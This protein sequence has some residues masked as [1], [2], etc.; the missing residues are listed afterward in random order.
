MTQVIVIVNALL[1]ALGGCMEPKSHFSALV[2]ER[3]REIRVLA[4]STVRIT[5]G[6]TW[7]EWKSRCSE[8]LKD[9]CD[10]QTNGELQFAVSRHYSRSRRPY[11]SS[12]L[13]I[14]KAGFTSVRHPRTHPRMHARTH[15][16]THTQTYLTYMQ[17]NAYV[18][19]HPLT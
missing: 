12:C 16:R 13:V 17:L 4:F 1:T 18:Y 3:G 8:Q 10:R 5:R 7:L 15:A 19:R 9:D 14:G 2:S 6:G 11:I